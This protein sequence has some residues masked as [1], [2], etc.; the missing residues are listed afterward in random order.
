M[1]TWFMNDPYPNDHHDWSQSL[2]W[3]I[4]WQRNSKPSFLAKGDD[5]MMIRVGDFNARKSNVR[6]SISWD[7]LPKALKRCRH[8]N[9]F[10]GLAA[11]CSIT[12]YSSLGSSLLRKGFVRFVNENSFRSQNCKRKLNLF[13]KALTDLLSS[14]NSYVSAL[15]NINHI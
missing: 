13:P 15:L 8:K 11:I 14:L 2:L 3:C 10:F 5:A 6:C 9:H 12:L 4:G 7:V 1:S